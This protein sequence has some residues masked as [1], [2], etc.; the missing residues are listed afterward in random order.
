MGEP[1]GTA[2][3]DVPPRDTPELDAAANTDTASNA[4][5]VSRLGK[6][7]RWRLTLIVMAVVGV[8]LLLG[9]LLLV[10][11]VEGTLVNDVRTRNEAA[12]AAMAEVISGGRVPS[13]LDLQ[14]QMSTEADPRHRR[15]PL[16]DLLLLGGR[17]PRRG[18]V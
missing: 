15:V 14:H 18:R 10:K 11:W 7:V 2:A 16:V 12:L 9:A 4:S 1:F 17:G 6:S 3:S 5:L 13:E 8:T